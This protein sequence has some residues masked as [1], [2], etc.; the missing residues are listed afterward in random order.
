MHIKRN[1]DELIAKS[2]VKVGQRVHLLVFAFVFPICKKF[3]LIVFSRPWKVSSMYRTS[4]VLPN[5]ILVQPLS[6]RLLPF[7]HLVQ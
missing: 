6:Q 4:I 5:R 7:F 1:I 3:M 2:H